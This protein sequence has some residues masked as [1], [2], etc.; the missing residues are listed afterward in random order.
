MWRVCAIV[1]TLQV[2]SPPAQ[3]APLELPKLAARV[4][5]Q[6]YRGWKPAAPASCA[7]ASSNPLRGDF[8][9]D[10][11]PDWA[12][13]MVDGQNQRHLVVLIARI[14]E[15]D[16][17]DLGADAGDTVM[18]AIKVGTPYTEPGHVLPDYF[19][20]DA[21]GD[22]PCAKPDHAYVWT[23]SGFRRVVLTGGGSS[24]KS[25]SGAVA[26]IRWYRASRSRGSSLRRRARP[27]PSGLG[28][29]RS[30]SGAR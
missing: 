13:Q 9:G 2:T 5:T 11:R 21:I 28:H 18:A 7:A 6:Q 30:T 19:G 4:L 27:A 12:L 26:A 10:G 25:A 16:A 8:N 22:G 20:T 23:G 17:F 29:S 24:A 15:F 3:P 1:L 14:D